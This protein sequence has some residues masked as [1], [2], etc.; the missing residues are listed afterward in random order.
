MDNLL[1]RLPY[2]PPRYGPEWGSGG[3]FGLKYH[4]STL[5]FNLAFEANAYFIREDKTSIYRY[6]MVGYQPVSGGDTYNAVDSIDNYIYFGGWVHAPAKYLGRGERGAT[7]SFVNKY[8]HVHE[9]NV[10][11]DQVRLLWKENIHHPTDWAGE[12]SE[13]IYNPVEDDLLIARAD[14]MT[15]LGVYKLDRRTGH[16][17]LVSKNLL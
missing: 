5:Y 17:G 15:N 3:I 6:E 16:T 7:I 2:F 9:Y 4:R 14:G 10:D 11:N 8:S 1:Y 12:V 13:I